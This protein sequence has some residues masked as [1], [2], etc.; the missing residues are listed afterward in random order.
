MKIGMQREAEEAVLRERRVGL[1][2]REQ[3]GS[4]PVRWIDPDDASASS[5][6]RPDVL[7][8]PP[9]DLPWSIETRSQDAHRELLR[10]VD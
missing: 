7:I 1:R 2:Q 10:R 4:R 5:L 6:G 3:R 8:R 9:R